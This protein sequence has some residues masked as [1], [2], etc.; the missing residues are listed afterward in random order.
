M[1]TWISFELNILK[2]IQYISNPTL[3][4]FFVSISALGNGSIFW[5]AF[6]LLCLSTKEYSRES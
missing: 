6:I 3:D 5:I 1:T 2:A 4:S